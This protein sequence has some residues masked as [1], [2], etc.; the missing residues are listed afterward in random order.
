VPA[1]ARDPQ[2]EQLNVALS[3]KHLGT[4]WSVTSKGVHLG[5]TLLTAIAMMWEL[6]YLDP[7]HSS[8]HFLLTLITMFSAGGL[9]GAWAYR[10]KVEGLEQDKTYLRNE[11][12][13]MAS[14]KRDLEKLFLKGRQTSEKIKG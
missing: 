8:Q 9:V 5:G 1:P 12:N 13:R 10:A 2:K 14:E 4:R 11:V 7:S 6:L 3:G